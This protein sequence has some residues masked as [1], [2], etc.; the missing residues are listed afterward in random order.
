MSQ[1]IA[2]TPVPIYIWASMYHENHT[3][4]SAHPTNIEENTH[5]LTESHVDPARVHLLTDASYLLRAISSKGKKTVILGGGYTPFLSRELGPVKKKFQEETA[6][7]TLNIWGQCAGANMLCDSVV[8]PWEKKIKHFQEIKPFGLLPITADAGI[9]P[10]E[11]SASLGDLINRR[12]VTLVSASDREFSAYWYRG[13]KFRYSQESD[14]VTV[15]C[16]ELAHY[17]GVKPE[18]K[19]GEKPIAEVCG[20][21]ANGSK[22]I[23]SGAHPEIVH[24]DVPREGSS[25]SERLSS[26]KNRKHHLET[27]YKTLNIIPLIPSRL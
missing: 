25:A 7:G 14:T 8:V 3:L 15:K 2:Q 16:S 26:D 4:Y 22:I 9:F 20:T 17:V 23:A 19:T 18:T 11:T 24:V 13:S 6:K 1:S 21:T 5:R 10:I 27:V 12:I